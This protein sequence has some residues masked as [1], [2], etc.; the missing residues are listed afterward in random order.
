MIEFRIDGKHIVLKPETEVSIDMENPLFAEGIQDDFSMPFDMPVHGNERHMGHAEQL[1]HHDRT[2]TWHD[3]TMLVD[4]TLL[5]TGDITLLGS[6]GHDFSASFAVDAFVS[7]I[8]GRMLPE[9]LRPISIDTTNMPWHGS[10]PG[11]AFGGTHQFPIH[12]NPSLYGDENPDWYPSTQE[13]ARDTQYPINSL[14]SIDLIQNNVKR[15]WSYQATTD[16]PANSPPPGPNW[17]RTAFGVANARNMATGDFRYNSTANIY[18]LVPWFYLKWV[19]KQSCSA[20]GFTVK[21]EFMDDPNTHEVLV[22]NATNIDKNKGV[23]GDYF[24]RAQMSGPAYYDPSVP[25]NQWRMPFDDDT[26]VPNTDQGNRW[27]NELFTFTPDEDGL[28]RFTG[29]FKVVPNRPGNSRPGGRLYIFNTNGTV[30]ASSYVVVGRFGDCSFAT[31]HQFGPGDVGQSF[32]FVFTQY[33][34]SAGSGTPTWP[35]QPSDHYVSGFIRGWLDLEE[36]PLLVPDTLIRPY[37]HVP[38]VAFAD[39]LTDILETFTLKQTVDL[40]ER[41]ITLDYRRSVLDQPTR[42]V[43]E[44]TPRLNGVVALEHHTNPTGVTLEYQVD[45]ATTVKDVEGDDLDAYFSDFDMPAPTRNNQLALLLSTRELLASVFLNGV[46]HWESTGYYLPPLQLGNANNSETIT[47]GATPPNMMYITLE[48]RPMIIPVWDESDN[49]RSSF[50]V[51]KQQSVTPSIDILPPTAW[52][53]GYGFSEIDAAPL[54]LELRPAPVPGLYTVAPTLYQFHGPWLNALIRA[55]AVSFNL[56]V[57]APFLLGKLWHGVVA[58]LYQHFIIKHLPVTI[59]AGQQPLLAENVK[60]LRLRS[61]AKEP[62]TPKYTLQLPLPEPPVPGQCQQPTSMHLVVPEYGMDPQVYL[63]LSDN[64]FDPWEGFAS[65][66]PGGYYTVENG[67]TY[68][69]A[70]VS[71]QL[72]VDHGEICLFPSN[73]EGQPTGNPVVSAA[74]V[75]YLGATASNF[76][77]Q[78]LYGVPDLLFWTDGSVDLSGTISSKRVHLETESSDPSK[79]TY[80]APECVQFGWVG[81]LD[82]FSFVAPNLERLKIWPDIYGQGDTAIPAIT[83]TGY[84]RLRWL[85]L[86]GVNHALDFSA[87]ALIQ[88]IRLQQLSDHPVNLINRTQLERLMLN[89]EN[90]PLLNLSGCNSLWDVDIQGAPALITIEPPERFGNGPTVNFLCNSPLPQDNVDAILA[91]IEAN[92]NATSGNVT[93][94]GYCAPPSATGLLIANNLIARGLNVGHN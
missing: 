69:N 19:L 15:K 45:G 49:A 24:F 68:S 65:D 12:Y 64:P 44:I 93:L 1:A 5:Y 30:V 54:S 66:L 29:T 21:G 36:D 20:L 32:Y 72:F 89:G 73:A 56:L 91:A 43:P 27:N 7:R 38:D 51:Y 8:K 10:G 75:C 78:Q 74:L 85:L 40:A 42:T 83:L 70:F 53:W 4:G 50:C 13:W 76:G 81:P 62:T 67:T 35:Q 90:I 60:A 14:V 33:D 28:W 87:C 18:S 17:R 3:A 48:D 88:Y 71:P 86:A 39:W 57:D 84:S 22:P 55:E 16:V 47:L 9:L 46:F 41:T 11:Y 34:Q 25:W 80:N 92:D 58:M 61:E 31:A 52:S 63:I 2:I 6:N 79:I 37:R 77:L 59:R 26:T 94:M 23:N 82:L